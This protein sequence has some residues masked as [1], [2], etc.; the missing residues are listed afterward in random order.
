MRKKHDY[1]GRFAPSP[2]GA[3]HLGCVAAA[4]ITWLAARQAGGHLVLRVEDLD[5]ARLVSG[6]VEEQLGDLLWLG[7]DWDEGPGQ[8]VPTVSFVQSQRLPLYAAALATLEARGLL[9]LCDCSRKEIAS[10]ASAPH[11]GEDG[12]VYPGL[13]RSYG[14]KERSFR[15]PPA[16]RVRVPDV[17]VVVEDRFQGRFT[18]HLAR[19][20]GDF[21]LRRGDG[22]PT[23]QLAVVVDDLAMGITEVVRG[24]DLL[25]SAPR[26]AWLAEALGGKAPNF[27]H[28]ALLREA[29]GERLAKRAR[30]A[31]L[32]EYRR[33]GRRPAEVLG[34]LAALFGLV[35]PALARGGLSAADLVDMADLS[36]LVGRATVGLPAAG[37]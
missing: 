17:E 13:C 6:M 36:G 27:A 33:A 35:D 18:Q 20:V 19:E 9:Y 10:L 26:Q 12:P 30:H 5:S 34:T 23:Y 37:I 15:R 8:D 7:L 21:V 1:R 16:I 14:M 11:A 4:L 25:G 3:L 24:A 22:V 28:L 2:T 29:G 31:S 32:G